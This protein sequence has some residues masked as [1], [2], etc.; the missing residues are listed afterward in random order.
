MSFT[1]NN[2]NSGINSGSNI[3]VAVVVTG[4]L[5]GDLVVAY[6]NDNGGVQSPITISDGT[7][8]LTPLTEVTISTVV[9]SQIFYLLSSVASG[10]VTY[11]ATWNANVSTPSLAVYV[12]TP[13][14]TVVFDQA[15]QAGGAGVTTKSSGNITTTGTDELVFGAQ[16][17]ESAY[18]SLTINGS[19]PTALVGTGSFRLGYLAFGSTFTGDCFAT[20]TSAGRLAAHIASFKITGGGAPVPSIGSAYRIGVWAR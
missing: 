7:T 19:A 5:A 16:Q 2:G 11:T 14:G 4:V 20:Q 18:I 6:A 15:N 3:S 9:E 13:S 12:F 17:G 10:S 8:S 1:L